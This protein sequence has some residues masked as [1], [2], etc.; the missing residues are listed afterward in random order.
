MERRGE[1]KHSWSLESVNGMNSTSTWI[2]GFGLYAALSANCAA[3]RVSFSPPH[4]P[5]EVSWKVDTHRDKLE[6]IIV[7]SGVSFNGAVT[8]ANMSGS[9]D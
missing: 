8:S 6:F 3:S 4:S 2:Y 9:I 1:G 7:G 5:H